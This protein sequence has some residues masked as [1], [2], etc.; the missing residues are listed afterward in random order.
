MRATDL[1]GRTFGHWTVLSRAPSR[2]GR[3]YWLCQCACGVTRE[4]QGGNLLSSLS[5][6]C[7]CSWR[8]AHLQKLRGTIRPLTSARPSQPLT[9]Q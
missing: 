2:Y 9:P 4:V 5:Q 8:P 1:T 3:A 7:G 6:G